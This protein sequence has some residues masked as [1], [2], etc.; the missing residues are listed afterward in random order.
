MLGFLRLV[1]NAG[2]FIPHELLV[3]PFAEVEVVVMLR[4][5]HLTSFWT[6][7]NFAINTRVFHCF[8]L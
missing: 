4:T 2:I 7:C 1:L 3:L 8:F 5:R 6:L